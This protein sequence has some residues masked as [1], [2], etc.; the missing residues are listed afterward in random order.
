MSALDG[1][2]GEA[3]HDLALEEKDEVWIRLTQWFLERLDRPGR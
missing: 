1:T 3:G 2:L